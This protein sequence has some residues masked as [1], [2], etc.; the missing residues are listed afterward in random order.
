MTVRAAAKPAPTPTRRAGAW[1]RKD[2][3][4]LSG[5]SRDELVALLSRLREFAPAAND[6]ATRTGHLAGKLVANLF[7]EDSTRTRTSFA[8]AAARLSGAVVDLS[9]SSSSTKKGESLTD[10]A[11]VVES[12]GVSAIVVRARQAG[13]AAMIAAAVK[14]PVVNAGDGRHEHPT[15]GL[16]D[17]YTI[18]EAHGRLADFDLSGLGLAIVG[19]VAN[20]RVARSAIAGILTLGGRV[21]CAGPPGFV[22]RGLTALGCDVAPDLEAVLPGA[23]AVMMLR[24]QFERQD[25]RTAGGTPAPPGEAGK[26]PEAAMGGKAIASL[27]EYRELYGLTAGRAARMKPGAIVMHPGPI[28]RGLEIDGEVADGPR[29]VIL[30]QTAHGV[31]ARMAA[32][33][34]CVEAAG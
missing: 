8:I 9:G 18:A 21:V 16:L 32:L 34:F 4:A 31:A 17:L 27:R 7:F 20:S 13:A 12:M 1:C 6:P 30:K 25:E 5:L 15:Q 26:V 24:I 3:L 2:L 10:T 22:G 29:S 11:R 19:D 28:N 23:D 14:C 33:S